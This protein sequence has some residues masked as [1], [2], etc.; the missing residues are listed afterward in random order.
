MRARWSI[1]T[2]CVFDSRTGAPINGARVRLIDAPPALPPTVVGDDG[3][4]SY[5]SEMVTG[6]PVTDA[7][8]TVY[9]LPAG[10]FRFPLVAPGNYR[11]KS[12]RRPAMHFRRR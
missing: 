9:A 2:A 6:S 5:P 7:G 3:V 11:S 8:G 4:S 12:T 10:V 1:R